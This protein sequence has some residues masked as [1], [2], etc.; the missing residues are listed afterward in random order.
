MNYSIKISGIGILCFF[1]ALYPIIP[2]YFEIGGL[3]FNN[4]L[5][6][7]CL[8]VLIG[9]GYWKFGGTDR[10][11]CTACLALY[12]VYIMINNLINQEYT[13]VFWEILLFFGMAGVY[14]SSVNTKDKFLRIID[15]MIYAAGVVCVLGIIE[16]V[17]NFNAFE[18]LNTSNAVIHHNAER[19]GLTRIIGFGYQTITY[20]VYIMFMSA[21][22]FYRLS[23]LKKCKK[24]RI[25]TV[26]YVL[27]WINAFL[28][29]SR[30]AI[31]AMIFCQA[32]LAIKC[33]FVKFVKRVTVIALVAIV[34]GAIYSSITDGINIVSAMVEML[35]ALVDESASA[36]ISSS[37]GGENLD[38][39][40][41]RILLYNWVANSMDNHWLI[42]W[43]RSK[44]FVYAYTY[45]NQWA[46]QLTKSS[47]EVQY[48]Y[49][50]Y[51]YGIIGMVLEIV[52]YCAVIIS[53]F[54]KRITS[55]C[56]WEGKLSFNFVF[57]IIMISY[58]LVLFAVNRSAEMRALYVMV[59]MFLA[60]NSN[61]S[62][63]ADDVRC[64]GG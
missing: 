13:E 14:I 60:Y 49:T 40:G 16:S 46:T 64:I 7:I 39:V 42:G 63:L 30:S 52:A 12:I 5:M 21:F 24:K 54:T 37:F 4:L 9:I 45:A 36:N 35:I 8:I 55:K 6:L 61:H 25:M 41:H 43:G 27:M 22:A 51:H 10:F 26:I 17:T 59:F 32:I 3:N 57:M 23:T 53:A 18:I 28:T 47:I 44:E 56:A 19:F 48:L 15:V 34:V 58:L 62:A 33:G 38:G 29:I 50:L 20:C 11:Y 1:S 31:L 2:S